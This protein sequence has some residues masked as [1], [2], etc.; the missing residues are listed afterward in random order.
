MRGMI[1]NWYIKVKVKKYLL[2]VA[3]TVASDLAMELVKKI[4]FKH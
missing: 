4:L 1:A 3:S 2:A